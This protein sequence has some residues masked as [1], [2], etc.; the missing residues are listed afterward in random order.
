MNNVIPLKRSEL[1]QR[2]LMPFWSWFMA[3]EQEGLRKHVSEGAAWAVW[4]AAIESK[5]AI[6]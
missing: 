5:K 1:L 3:K 4:A 2:E 6:S